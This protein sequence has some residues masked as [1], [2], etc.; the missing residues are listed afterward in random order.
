M[1]R[2]KIR[3]EK[4]KVSKRR[5]NVAIGGLILA[6]MGYVLGILT[7]PKSGK[8]TREEIQKKAI[9]AKKEAEDNLKKIHSELNDLLKKA[10]STTQSVG[11]TTKGNL[12]EAVSIAQDAREKVREIL[13]AI[14]EGEPEDK[15]LQ[16][17]LAEAKKA[18]TH[19]KKYVTKTKK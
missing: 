18:A 4:I 17:A 12:D 19:L 16:K 9:A 1:K 15:D 7:A 5:G 3:G 13:S 10:K 14:H 2:R 8:A 11:K 6:A